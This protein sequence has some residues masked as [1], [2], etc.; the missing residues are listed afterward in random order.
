[1]FVH[2]YKDNI[3]IYKL[4]K[5][6]QYTS[7]HFPLSISL[8]YAYLVPRKGRID[9]YSSLTPQP[10]LVSSLFVVPLTIAPVC[11]FGPFD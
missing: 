3:V 9:N 4:E 6:L 11:G 7:I 10:L 8:S 1:M 2:V 5:E